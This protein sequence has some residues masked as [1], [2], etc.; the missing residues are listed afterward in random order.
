MVQ[1]LCHLTP[2]PVLLTQR[3]HR[4]LRQQGIDVC[5]DLIGIEVA[6]VTLHRIPLCIKEELFKVPG[7]VGPAHW[8]PQRTGCA[9]KATSREN[10][11]VDVSAAILFGVLQITK[12]NG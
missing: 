6:A 9:T 2:P 10:D 1:L 5:G 4:S 12:E 8:C 3:A 7:N 11:R